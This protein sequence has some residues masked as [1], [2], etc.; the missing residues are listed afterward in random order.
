MP[1]DPRAGRGAEGRL[2]GHLASLNVNQR[3][4][5][6]EKPGFRV[7][8]GRFTRITGAVARETCPG[9]Q[10]RLR[11][12]TPRRNTARPGPCPAGEWM[13]SG[14]EDSLDQSEKRLEVNVS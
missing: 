12:G 2:A 3:P 13:L 8:S 4:S 1:G 11:Q 5:L 9:F 14:L 6:S 10:R 7:S